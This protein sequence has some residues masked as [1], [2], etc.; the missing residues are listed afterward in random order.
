LTEPLAEIAARLAIPM[1]HA[2][3]VLKMVHAMDPPGIGARSLE[4]CLSI[5]LRERDRFD[6]AMAALVK[7]L[8]L[9]AK[10]DLQQ[11]KKICGVDGE[12]LAEMIAEIRQLTPK[13][14][15]AFGGAP[16]QSVIPDVIVR[17]APD[18]TWFIELMPRRCRAFSSTRPIMQKFRAQRKTLARKPFLP[19]VYRPRTG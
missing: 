17:A 5:Q 2:E 8:D 11:L 13:P 10:R 4:E 16:V 3:A 15:L 7:H 6:P 14:G 12:D 19:N 1:A 18:G 9:L